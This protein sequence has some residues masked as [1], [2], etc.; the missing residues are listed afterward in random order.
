MPNTAYLK[1][2][3]SNEQSGFFLISIQYQR[4]YVLSEQTTANTCKLSTIIHIS[5]LIVFV[6]W[7]FLAMIIE[8]Y[9][10]YTLNRIFP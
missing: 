8:T 1:M 10:M 2:D 4:I 6:N 9:I 7:G 3:V 5:N